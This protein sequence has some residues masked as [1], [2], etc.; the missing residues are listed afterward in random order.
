MPRPAGIKKTGGRAIGV[1]N[2]V[3]QDVRLCIAMFAEKNVSKLE[4]WI[5]QTAEGDPSRNIKPAPDKAAELFLKAIEYHV[6]KLARS[7]VTG[8]DGGAIVIRATSEEEML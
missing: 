6:P 7:E 1:P 2:K 4:E 3:T 8:K 5:N